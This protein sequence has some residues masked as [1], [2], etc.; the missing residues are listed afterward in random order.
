MLNKAYIEFKDIVTDDGRGTMF[1]VPFNPSELS[2]ESTALKPDRTDEKQEMTVRLNMKLVFDKSLY[3]ESV[4]E[5]TERFLAA[6]R[7]PQKR[8]VLFHWNEMNFDGLLD[9]MTAS[10]E[11][12]S[13]EGKPVRAKIDIGISARG[14][15]MAASEWYSDYKALFKIKE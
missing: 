10:Y 6:A 13:N 12:F 3:M 9:R 4:Q 15:S 14:S 7:D 1:Q 2:F 11:M 8:R 5:E